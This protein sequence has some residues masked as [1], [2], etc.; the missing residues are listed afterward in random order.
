MRNRRRW[1]PVDMRAIRLPGAARLGNLGV[2]RVLRMQTIVA[3][4]LGG[5]AGS[6]ARYLA[7]EWVNRRAAPWGT[8][9]VNIT[10]SLMIG[11]VIG[12]YTGRAEDSLLRVA[13]AAGFLGGFT[14]FS[15]WMAETVGLIE[16]GS[17][18]QAVTNLAVSIGL[19]LLAA[20]GGIVL[21]RALF[22]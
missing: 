17:V 22:S 15:S 14:T 12:F 3:V 11:L 2:G 9:A 5:A 16:A 10:G 20:A 6:V 18:V 21:G 19:G 13:M 8:L 4:G 1:E 7:T